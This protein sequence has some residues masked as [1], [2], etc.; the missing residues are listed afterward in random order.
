MTFVD[1]GANV[2]YYTLLASHLVGDSG[3]VYAFEPNPK[4]FAYLRKNLA[5]NGCDNVTAVQK[6]VS[7]GTG[8]E[9]LVPEG[10][11]ERSY[12][13]SS[14]SGDGTIV[15]PTVSLDDYFMIEGWPSIS[16]IKMDIEGGETSA[17]KG[18]REVSQKNPEMKIIVEFNL[19]AIQRAGGTWEDFASALKGLGYD[20]AH[21][22]ER[23]LMPISLDQPIPS[24]RVLHN[25]LLSNS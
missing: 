13:S 11:G 23:G 10:E 14:N 4:T 17:A 2:G 21:I 12:L 3:R 16:L 1:V 15:V 20:K 25:L 5:I 7:K 18:M 9:R 22:I 24:K 19:R 6:A 8:F